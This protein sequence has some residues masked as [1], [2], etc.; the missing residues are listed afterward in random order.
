MREIAGKIE[1]ETRFYIASLVLL[2]QYLLIPRSGTSGAGEHG[3][4]L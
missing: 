1:Q 2:A 3:L 4:C